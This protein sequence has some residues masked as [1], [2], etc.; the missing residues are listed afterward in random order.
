MNERSAG[1]AGARFD[2]R[3]RIRFGHCDPAGIVFFPQYFVL[4]AGLVEDW[5]S[6]GLGIPYRDFF[7]ARR[8]GLPTV[9]LATEF[10]AIS[11][12][13]DDVLLTLQVQELG[14]RSLTLALQ[15]LGDDGGLRVKARQVIV[16]TSLDSHR[17][18]PIPPDLREAIERFMAAR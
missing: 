10:S 17:A 9:R 3:E 6:E 8:T 18:V 5:V 16:T 13:G 7:G 15:C 2:K 11:R 1:A 14:T 4:F 12:L